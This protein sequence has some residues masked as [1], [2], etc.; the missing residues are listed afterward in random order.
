MVFFC[1]LLKA[2]RWSNSSLPNE[3]L[4]KFA[5]KCI[6]NAALQNFEYFKWSEKE[7]NIFYQ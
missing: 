1:I 6:V 3:N 4:L 7:E 2:V 5:V